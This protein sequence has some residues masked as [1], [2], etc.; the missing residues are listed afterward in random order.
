MQKVR[1]E[2]IVTTEEIESRLQKH[3]KSMAEKKAEEAANANLPNYLNPSMVNVSQFKQVQEKRK[4]LWS[5][6]SEQDSANW[7][8][9]VEGEASEKFHRLMGI[10]GD[11]KEAAP[12]ASETVQK[13][14]QLMQDLQSDYDKSWNFHMSRGAGG[15]TGI[16]LGFNSEAPPQN[17]T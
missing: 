8:G 2:R 1:E 6:T 13:S 9:T 16:G 14:K 4:L 7:A 17:P 12:Q 11:V 3:A 5:K 15:V 10:H